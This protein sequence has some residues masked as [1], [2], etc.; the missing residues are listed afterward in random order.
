MGGIRPIG[1]LA[2]VVAHHQ[3]EDDEGQHPTEDQT[4]QYE[5]PV[6]RIDLNLQRSRPAAGTGGSCAYSFLS[7]ADE[8]A[9]HLGGRFPRSLELGGIP[10]EVELSTKEPTQP[11]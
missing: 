7:G 8:A 5:N 3:V 11:W 1:L 6:E 10:L 4:E 9:V 2:T